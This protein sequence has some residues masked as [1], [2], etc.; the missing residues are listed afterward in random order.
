MKSTRMSGWVN[1]AI[2]RIEYLIDPLTRVVLAPYSG[3]RSASQGVIRGSAAAHSGKAL[4]FRPG[5]FYFVRLR[6]KMRGVASKGLFGPVHGKPKA[7]RHVLRQS[8]PPATF[9][10]LS[11]WRK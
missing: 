10:H 11:G 9:P 2:D 8:R 6:L 4:P 3:S 7:Y 1:Q 5:F